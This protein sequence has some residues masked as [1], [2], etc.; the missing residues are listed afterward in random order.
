M[1]ILFGEGSERGSIPGTITAL[2]EKGF[3]VR[4]RFEPRDVSMEIDPAAKFYFQENLDLDSIHTGETLAFTGKV[5]GGDAKAPTTLVLRSIAPADSDAPETD[6]GGG[7][8][9]FGG[10]KSV[11]ATVKGKITSLDP[12]QVQTEDGHEVKIKVPG[13]LTYARYRPIDRGTLKA[14]QKVLIVGRQRGNGG[15]ADLIV[16]NPSL[17]M[18]PGF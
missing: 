2:T 7:D 8:G 18:G 6:V 10:G 17:V 13:Q 5:I 14:D 1:V 11:T 4:P 3:T 15:I 16:V 9:P 12:L